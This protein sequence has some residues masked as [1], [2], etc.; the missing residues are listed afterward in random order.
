MHKDVTLPN[1]SRKTFGHC[2]AGRLE[3]LI[4]KAG[5]WRPEHAQHL[6]EV[7]RC[8]TCAVEAKRKS[9][10]KTAIP[11]ASNFNQ[12][13]T[14]DLKYNTR[15]G[16]KASPYILYIIDAFTRYK[17]AVFLTDKSSTSVI[18]ALLVNWI[19]IFGRPTTVH[20]DRGSEFVNQEM[21]ALCDKYDIKITTTASYSPNQ[22]GLNEKN[23]HYVDF[24]M[25]KMML[26]DSSCSP[27]IALTWAIHASNVLENRF[28]VSPSI[29]VFGRN[30][31]SH[32]DLSPTAPSTL[33]SNV[34]IS[35]RIAAHLNALSKAREAF[36]QAESSKT[37][38][39]ALKAK[40]V[41][42]NEVIDV[43]NWIY[44]KN[45]E[46]KLWQG[47]V[48]VVMIDNKSIYTIR[49]NK[50]VSINKDHVVLQR[51]EDENHENLLTLP[52]LP[53]E[54]GNHSA[55]SDSQIQTAE[56]SNNEEKRT[57]NHQMGLEIIKNA[58]VAGQD[59]HVHSE[60]LE[61][62]EDQETEIRDINKAITLDEG[63]EES[64]DSMEG[65]NNHAEA[66]Q[67]LARTKDNIEEEYNRIEIDEVRTYDKI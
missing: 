60:R 28:G 12:L 23:H 24:M 5:K 21:Q 55:L 43:G 61:S 41:K 11:R 52:P 32:P 22:N 40:V 15:F 6:E 38:A 4:Q 34:K 48:K 66:E 44:F 50:L 63:N 26:A 16:T 65:E 13:V 31:I 35:D 58:T 8:Q 36:I 67:I 62:Y 3:K 45:L 30:V 49:N 25:V 20:F 27:E 17:T 37:I 18:E 42:R 53:S 39:D 54:E 57:N 59:Q 33:E 7:R 10:P 2:T 56:T 51:S 64:L 47:P 29:L 14:L 9:L 1:E 46:S 19:R